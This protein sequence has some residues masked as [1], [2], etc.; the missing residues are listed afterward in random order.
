[1]KF[2]F[3]LCY[4]NLSELKFEIFLIS[5]LKPSEKYQNFYL[6]SRNSQAILQK[7]INYALKIVH[8]A[9]K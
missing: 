3:I 9:V 5:T 6:N 1:M 2:S 8:H 7:I 4:W